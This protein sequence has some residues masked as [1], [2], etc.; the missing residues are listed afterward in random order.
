MIF[1]AKELLNII[2]KESKV[3]SVYLPVSDLTVCLLVA[4]LCW[5]SDLVNI[6]LIF[7][8]ENIS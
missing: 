3:L 1:R 2:M 5:S 8:Y 6:T 4:L 7:M